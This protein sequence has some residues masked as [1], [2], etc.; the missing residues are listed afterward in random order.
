MMDEEAFASHKEDIRKNGQKETIKTFRGDILDGRNRHRACTELDIEPRLESLP[1]DTDP[2]SYVLSLNLE[3]R[4]L[5]ES[6]RAMVAAKLCN[7]TNGGDRKSEEIRVRNQTVIPVTIGDAAQRLSVGRSTV[8]Q[9]K[10]V[11]ERAAQEIK[12]MVEIGELPLNAA[13]TVAEMPI[14]RQQKLAAEGVAAV[15]RP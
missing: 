5:N 9:A 10:A 13:V 12:A 4:H 15:D 8:S 7:M 2:V 3:R 6:Q 1:D 11:N 14:A